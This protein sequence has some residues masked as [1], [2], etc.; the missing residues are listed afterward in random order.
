VKVFEHFGHDM[1]S[2]SLVH[3]QQPRWHSSHV[4]SSTTAIVTRTTFDVAYAMSES[5][6]QTGL[7]VA[8]RNHNQNRHVQ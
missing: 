6:H 5:K 2:V 4:V 3:Q 7:H 8:V 1:L